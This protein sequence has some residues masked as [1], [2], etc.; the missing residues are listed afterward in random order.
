M[1]QEVVRSVY[2]VAGEGGHA[3]QARRLIQG[4]NFQGVALV[5]MSSARHPATDVLLLE[6]RRK[7]N[8]TI[9][10]TINAVIVNTLRSFSSFR[11]QP[12]G[13][14]ISTGPALA[15]IPAVIARFVY[16]VPVVHIETWSRFR[17]RSI[18]GR[19]MIHIADRF[20]YQNIDLS[21]QYE[22]ASYSGRL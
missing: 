16:N 1:K 22:G 14:L 4:L 6:V 21:S 19:F 15:C 7:Y 20:Y 11:S 2:L 17:S 3:E 18:T 8:P 10:A 5:F 12:P 9:L 13:L